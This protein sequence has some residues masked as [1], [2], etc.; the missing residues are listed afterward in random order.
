[1]QNGLVSIIIPSFNRAELIG[2][3]LES[4]INQQY[5]NWEAIVVDDLSTDASLAVIDA[6]AKRDSRIKGFSRTGPTKGASACRNQGFNQSQGEYILFLDCDDILTPECLS[7]RVAY[8]SARVNLGFV[9]YPC[10]VFHQTPGDSVMLWNANTGAGDIDRY[11]RNDPPWQTSSALIRRSAVEHVGPWDEAAMSWQDWEYYL[12]YLIEM[13]PY[14]RTGT[15]D[16]YWRA[17]DKARGSI[18]NRGNTIPHFESRLALVIKIARMLKERGELNGTRQELINW[19]CFLIAT[20][21][22]GL[23]DKDNAYKAWQAAADLECVQGA[24]FGAGNSLLRF[25]NTTGRK[26]MH[27]SMRQTWPCFDV[28][29]ASATHLRSVSIPPNWTPLVSCVIPAFN[30]EQ[31][32]RKT[33]ESILSQTMTNFEIVVVN[34]GSTDSTEGILREYKARDPRVKLISRPNTGYVPALIEA[35]A[36][37]RGALIARMDADDIAMPDRFEKQV[38][39]MNAHPEVVLLGGSYDLIDSEGRRL[40]TQSQPSDH[41]ALYMLCL[42]GTTPICHPLSMFRR[43]TYDKVGG[44]D[45]SYCPA[46]DLELW[47]RMSEVGNLACLNDVLLQYRLHASSVST[48]E[49]SKQMAAIRRACEAASQRLGKTFELRAKN[50]R[51]QAT[52]SEGLYKQMLKYGWWAWGSG[53]YANARHYAKMAMRTSP[54]RIPS[55]KL[56]LAAYFK[57]SN[58]KS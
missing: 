54:W 46:E 29:K 45:A 44:Y 16:F 8:L 34:D 30:C 25:W 42:Q 6:Y 31:Y 23:N 18:S 27:H 43:E 24:Q 58:S 47:L 50:I 57:K 26:R 48:R 12:R 22:M 35:I 3:T 4:V 56:L 2:Q 41:D 20:G 14:E 9:V 40:R 19:Q 13:I 36:A 21:F 39:F 37:S 10:R 7:N 49:N 28:F 55:W 5:A 11:L 53:E 33:M 15:A 52:D 17:P 38:R 51:A 1:M 32:I